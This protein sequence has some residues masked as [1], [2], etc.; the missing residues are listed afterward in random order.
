[1]VADKK[2]S[3]KQKRGRKYDKGGLRTEGQRRHWTVIVKVPTDSNPTND[4]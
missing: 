2:G 1:M 3:E 4:V